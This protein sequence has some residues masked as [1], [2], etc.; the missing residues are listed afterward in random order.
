MR[1]DM[2]PILV[3][4]IETNRT[5][6]PAII[7]RIREKIKPPATLKKEESIREWWA[8]QSGQAIDEKLAQTALNGLQGDV[9]AI[10][11]QVLVTETGDDADY[12]LS[13]LKPTIAIRKNDQSVSSFLGET[14]RRIETN[15]A[16]YFSFRGAWDTRVSG[17]NII[18]FDLPFLRQQSLR[19]NVRHM[20]FFPRRKEGVIDTMVELAGYKEFISLQD[21]AI[22]LSIPW[23]KT[24]IPGDQVPS[25]WESGNHEA[26]AHH[27]T[28]DVEATTAI[29]LKLLQ[30]DSRHPEG[31]FD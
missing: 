5:S 15:I 4:D 21:A 2:K 31:S 20:R 6:N 24:S 17:H 7:E 3:F 30:F 1:T 26:V 27:L 28:N 13:E 9:T 8:T 14:Y 10:G 29:A 18:N 19:Y 22:T 12:E 25:A 23:D 11:W 16:K